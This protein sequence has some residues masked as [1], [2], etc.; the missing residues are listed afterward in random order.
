M[1]KL[2]TLLLLLSSIYAS[3]QTSAKT[4]Y[5]QIGQQAY[6]FHALESVTKDSIFANDNVNVI[7]HYTDTLK[8]I[9]IESFYVETIMVNGKA[10]D[11]VT[12]DETVITRRRNNR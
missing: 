4:P 2:F 11:K 12:S 1:K 9:T 10:V 8:V 6:S 7:V 3:A 5:I